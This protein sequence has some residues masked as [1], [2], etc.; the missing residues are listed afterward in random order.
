MLNFNDF[1][2][3][4]DPV[5]RLRFNMEYERQNGYTVDYTGYCYQSFPTLAM[6]LSHAF[7]WKESEEGGFYWAAIYDRILRHA[8]LPM[9]ICLN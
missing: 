1:M 6:Y 8:S 9:D 4:L 3:L 2:D 5:E 7:S